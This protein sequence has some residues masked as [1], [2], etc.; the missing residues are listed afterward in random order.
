MK[1]YIPIV[2]GAALLVS[3]EQKQTTVNPRAQEQESNTTVVNPTPATS[4]ETETGPT[5][6]ATPSPSGETET[7][8]TIAPTPS[9]SGETD[10][11]DD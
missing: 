3:C 10:G 6:A 2:V 9:P 7:D 8:T 11:H 4:S 5:I 1:K